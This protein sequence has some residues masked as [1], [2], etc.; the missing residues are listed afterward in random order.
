VPVA[1]AAQAR[2]ILREYLSIVTERT[3]LPGACQQERDSGCRRLGFAIT[4]PSDSPNA[5]SE[6]LTS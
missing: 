1:L 6:T 4:S 5:I 3:V 2:A